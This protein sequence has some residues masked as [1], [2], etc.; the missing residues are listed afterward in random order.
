[1][2]AYVHLKQNGAVVTVGD[3]VEQGVV[4]GYSGAS[5]TRTP[6]LHFQ[7]YSDATSFRTLPVVF[8]NAGDRRLVEG[9]SYPAFE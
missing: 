2:S 4:I 5:G 1:M 7:V 8:R 9:R 3:A 6:H